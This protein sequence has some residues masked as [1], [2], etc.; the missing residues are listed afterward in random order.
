MEEIAR[1][2]Y[3]YKMSSQDIADQTGTSLSDVYDAIRKE[4]FCNGADTRNKNGLLG[5][6]MANLA[7]SGISIKDIAKITGFSYSKTSN[8][9]K[10]AMGDLDYAITKRLRN[11]N[12]TMDDAETMWRLYMGYDSK[13]IWSEKNVH[14]INGIARMYKNSAYKVN[15]I[16]NLISE[17]NIKEKRKC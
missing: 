10:N 8:L 16:I 6:D 7:K 1:M 17:R 11:M 15:Q 13:G 3:E 14:S 5:D 12:T 4:R 9:V 2:F